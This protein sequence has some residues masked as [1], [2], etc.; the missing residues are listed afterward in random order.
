MKPR[1]V[2]ALALVFLAGLAVGAM[3][4]PHRYTLAPLAGTTFARLDTMTGRVEISY[5]GQ[6]FAP[7]AESPAPK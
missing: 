2:L 7:V 6:P 1:A 5:A 4:S 3:Y